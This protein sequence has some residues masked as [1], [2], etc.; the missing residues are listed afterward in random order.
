[1]KEKRSVRL[2]ARCG[3]QFYY[4]ALSVK[5]H[6]LLK[7]CIFTFYAKRNYKSAVCNNFNGCFSAIFA[8]VS[9]LIGGA[10]CDRTG[11]RKLFI[12]WGYVIWGFTIM[13]F[14]LVPEA[15]RR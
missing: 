11:K 2:E 13:M 7:I 5:L 9:T 10:L 3:P 6:G 12:C 14:A 15:K 8:T 4:L 1:M